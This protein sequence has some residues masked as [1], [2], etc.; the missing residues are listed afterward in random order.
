MGP[1]FFGFDKKLF[2]F[3]F[4]WGTKNTDGLVQISGEQRFSGISIELDV[5]KA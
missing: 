3:Q 5:R 1:L 2:F 4:F